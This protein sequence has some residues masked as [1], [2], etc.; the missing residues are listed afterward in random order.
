MA[1][2]RLDSEKL[3]EFCIEIFE[4]LGISEA[5]AR[6]VADNLI[7][8]QL[9]GVQSHGIAKVINYADYIEKGTF[10][11]KPDI[12][13]LRESPSTIAIDGD[14]G[15][16]AVL[17]KFAMEKCIE[18]AKISGIASAT[19]SKGSHF[20][21]AGFY[22]MMALKENMIGIALCN[23]GN[24]MTI[25]GGTSRALGTNPISIAV[26]ANEK[27]P[28]VF[29]AATSEAA[30]NKIRIANTEGRDIPAGWA[31]D[32]NGQATVS[33]KK[34][35]E[36]A[37]IPFGGYKGSGL[38]VMVNILTTVLSGAF[39]DAHGEESKKG[40]TSKSVG[41]YFSA[42]DI[43]KFQDVDIFKTSIDLMVDELKASD[44]NEDVENIFMPGELEYLRKEENLRL[45]VEVGGGV[46]D[47]LKWLQKKYA[48][49]HRI[50]DCIIRAKT[51]SCGQN[52]LSS[53]VDI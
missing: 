29:D 52:I 49:N 9:R 44:R 39:L 25:Y 38:A 16:G 28:V 1:D 40:E 13:V 10:N 51:A 15:M 4:K 26:P 35:L 2:F 31:I 47:D 22:A 7:E 6:T 33:A 36:G 43:E 20:G 37:V 23:S 24:V 5:E 48:S 53:T 12:K 46:L 17:G 32:K 8:A 11:T 19:V 14:H 21:M 34:A 18:K 42:I 45:G 27:Y 41:F 3:A 30:F 50:E